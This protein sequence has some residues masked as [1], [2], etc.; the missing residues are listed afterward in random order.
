MNTQQKATELA[1]KLVLS[2]RQKQ[3]TTE[4]NKEINRLKAEL[5]EAMDDEGIPSITVEI[6]GGQ[7]KFDP[8]E[9]EN[10]KLAGP[11][12]GQKWDE[13]GV[14]HQWLKDKGEGGVIKTTVT[15][16]PNTRDK[17]IRDHLEAGGELPDFIEKTHFSNIKFNKK[18][19]TTL[20]ITLNLRAKEAASNNS[21]VS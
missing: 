9:V 11:V 7:I 19:I 15:V 17:L 14:F 4:I 16:P 2:E 1:K 21:R 18:N 12:A 13:C 10:F 8:D 20:A 5:N 6:A 3:V